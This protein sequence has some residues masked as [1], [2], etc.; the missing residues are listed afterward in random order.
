MDITQNIKVAVDAVVFGYTDNSLKI[1]LIQQKYGSEKD[2]W[3]LPGGFVKDNETLDKAVVREL[4]EETGI[5]ANYLEQLYTF[6]ALERD[7]R[8]RVIS[9]SYMALINP[10][11]YK[12]KAASDAK[13][14]KWFSI[15]EIPPLAYDHC[16]ILKVGK[17]RLKNKINYQPIGF[18]L[19]SKEFPFSDLENLYQTILDKKIDRRNFRKK[20]MSFGFLEETDKIHKPASGRPAKLYKF[21]QNKYKELESKGFH[22]EIKFA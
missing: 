12:I 6:G 10:N 11:N 1:L 16:A 19:L 7:P 22:F 5:N 2:K 17:E 21:N 13:D 8:G 3:G 15:N 9:I 4:E 20:I 14:V 18:E